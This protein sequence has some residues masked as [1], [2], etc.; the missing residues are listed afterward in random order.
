MHEHTELLVATHNAGKVR[1]LSR[2]LAD[3]PLR[4]RLLSEFPSITE[5]EETG[6][7]FAENATLKAL[8][9]ST[10]GGLL[11]LADD[12]GLAVDALGGAPG[13][14]SARYAGPHATY[15]ERMAKLLD[16]I[17]AT[18]DPKRRARFVCVIAVADPFAGFLETFDGCCEGRIAR[19]PRGA[20]GFGYDPVFIPEGHTQTF[21]ELPDEIKQT[22]SHRARA[23]EK[24]CRFLRERLTTRGLT[25]D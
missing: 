20:G 11:S 5:A 6:S 25:D 22:I 23:L 13:V 1:E 17:A 9:Y 16:E 12:S 18:G 3:V 2:R 8:H 4:L 21:G 10:L 15:A 24:A 14:Y 19:E 7:T